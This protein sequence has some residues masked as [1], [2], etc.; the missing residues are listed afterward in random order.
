MLY[1]VRNT[2]NQSPTDRWVKRVKYI[3]KMYSMVGKFT[4][5]VNNTRGVIASR[6]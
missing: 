1:R 6:K 4:H 3:L 2:E 5:M